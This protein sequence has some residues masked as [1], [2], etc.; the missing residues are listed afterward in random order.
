[1]FSKK[2]ISIFSVILLIIV[3]AATVFYTIRNESTQSV[4][5]QSVAIDINAT[6]DSIASL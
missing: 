2:I 1:M 4:K 5:G 3:I 6:S